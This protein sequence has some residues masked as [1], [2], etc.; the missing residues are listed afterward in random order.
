M[1]N[2]HNTVCL[3]ILTD[4]H[5]YIEREIRGGKRRGGEGRKEKNDKAKC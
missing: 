5:T 3:H 4:R 2:I 1:H